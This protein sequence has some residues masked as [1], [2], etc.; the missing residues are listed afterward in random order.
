VR[1]G[2]RNIDVPPPPAGSNVQS[3][4]VID[5]G[6]SCLTL[7]P[8]L[9]RQV[10]TMFQAIDPA[11]G[12]ALEAQGGVD[13]ARIDLAAWPALGFVFQG[14][15]GASVTITVE[16]KDYWQF[17]SNGPGQATT[18]LTGTSPHPGQS[19]LGLPLLTGY[20]VV[21]DRTA[22]DG[23]GVIKFAARPAADPATPVA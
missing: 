5:S 16:P 10:L 14:N 8:G 6:N 21:F 11:F 17:D 7:D 15:D 1:V 9:Y 18:G 3:N 20:F 23:N 2:D 19:I 12:T 13:Q 22:A 4:S